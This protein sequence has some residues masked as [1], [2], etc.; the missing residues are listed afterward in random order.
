MASKSE[1]RHAR[2]ASWG[3]AVPSAVGN[4]EI[5]QL[6]PWWNKLVHQRLLAEA[7]LVKNVVSTV[8][9]PRPRIGSET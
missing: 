1:Q 5:S 3:K 6:L 9:P 7:A 2:Q 8:M 4:K